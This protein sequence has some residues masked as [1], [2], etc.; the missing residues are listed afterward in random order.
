MNELMKRDMGKQIVVI[1]SG[2][3]HVGDCYLDGE[4][5]RIENCVN[6]RR[7]GTTKGLGELIAGPKKE[8]VADHCGLVLVPIGRVVFFL[9]V[10]GG[11]DV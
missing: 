11:W 8:T 7:W 5:L 4:M 9:K 2:F 6:I 10:V 3:V 1:D